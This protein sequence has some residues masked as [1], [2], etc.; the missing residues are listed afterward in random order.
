MPRAKIIIIAI[1]CVFLL[2]C[3]KFLNSPET[4][5][6]LPETGV[7]GQVVEA[8]AENAWVYAYRSSENGFRGPADYAA[9]VGGDGRYLLDLLPG[10][11]F[12]VAR[13]R[14]QGPLSGPPQAGDAWA[15]Y[16]SNPLVLQANEVQRIDFRLQKA[17][18][19]LLRSLNTGETGFI[20]RLLGPDRQPVVSAFA[21]AY[22][23]RNF[24]RMPDYSSAGTDADGRFL[25][26]VDEPGRYCLIARQGTRGQPRQG[27]LFGQ[28]GKG[29]AGCLEVE[30]GQLLDVGVFHLKA[31]MR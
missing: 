3:V 24:R 11:W 26:Y 7:Y 6:E 12:L 25:L 13:A 23:D 4:D 8:V 19:P 2:G 10:S 15:L 18:T 21:L 22:R 27:E 1:A 20:G 28:L 29:E 14:Q 31:Y 30:K 9:R 17:P 5:Y 16:Q